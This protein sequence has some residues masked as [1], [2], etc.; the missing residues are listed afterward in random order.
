MLI[1]DMLT[2]LLGI[3][4][5][6]IAYFIVRYVLLNLEE[7]GRMEERLRKAE[8]ENHRLK[9]QAAILAKPKTVDETIN[10]LNAGRF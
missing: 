4:G 3:F 9:I 7:M 6:A 5:S 1:S 8:E 2:L 10:D